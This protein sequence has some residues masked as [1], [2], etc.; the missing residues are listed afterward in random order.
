MDRQSEAFRNATDEDHWSG[1]VT[2]DDTV[3]QELRSLSDI[4]L[5]DDYDD[6]E[7]D[8]DKDGPKSLEEARTALD[9]RIENPEAPDDE[10]DRG[11]YDN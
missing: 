6:D 9:E 7:W 1:Q 5:P 2:D 4:T 11:A 8:T 10:I 3:H